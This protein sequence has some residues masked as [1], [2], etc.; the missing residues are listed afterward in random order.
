MI[1]LN[2]DDVP[3]G[4]DS[5]GVNSRSKIQVVSRGPRFDANDAHSE[6]VLLGLT[7]SGWI[8]RQHGDI[9]SQI[10]KSGSHLVNV[11]FCAAHERKVA[12][13]DHE[14]THWGA[15]VRTQPFLVGRRHASK[16]AYCC[17]GK[18]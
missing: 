7:R 15:P 13:G 3:I 18:P 1:A 14:N 17:H 6:H 11:R 12:R 16:G 10:N 8:R 9:V 5:A 2:V 4:F